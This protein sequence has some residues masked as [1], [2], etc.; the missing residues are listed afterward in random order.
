MAAEK[1]R[2]SNIE[3]F[4]IVMMLLI[5]LVTELLVAVFLLAIM[6]ILIHGPSSEA[7]YLT[8]APL[9]GADTLIVASIP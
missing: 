6:G 8:V 9:A 3:L 1:R 4:R 7:A 2:D 5:V